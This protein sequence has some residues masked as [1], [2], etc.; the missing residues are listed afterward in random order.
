M[1]KS[2][3][4]FFNPKEVFEKLSQENSKHKVNFYNPPDL[5]NEK[6]FKAKD[7]INLDLNKNIGLIDP[8]S[9][10]I[11]KKDASEYNHK[12]Y[13]RR[14]SDIA[15]KPCSKQRILEKEQVARKIFR[16]E[17]PFQSLA[18]INGIPVL[19]ETNSAHM[20][21]F[22]NRNW[23]ILGLKIYDKEFGDLNKKI[24]YAKSNDIPIVRLINAIDPLFKERYELELKRTGHQFLCE[25]LLSDL[26]HELLYRNSNF[27]KPGAY[28]NPDTKTIVAL[29]TDYYGQ[30]KSWALGAVSDVGESLPYEKQFHS[31]HA[32]CAVVNGKAIAFVAPTGT[33]KS[34]QEVMLGTMNLWIPKLLDNAPEKV[35]NLISKELIT[36]ARKIKSQFHSDDWLYIDRNFNAI[37]SERH[38][39]P[40]TSFIDDRIPEEE[41]PEIMRNAKEELFAKALKENVKINLD[42][43]FIFHDSIGM[44]NSR[45]LANPADSVQNPSEG[46]S[47]TAPLTSVN[48]LLKFDDDEGINA[49][50]KE[51][52]KSG[53]TDE[54]C[55]LPYSI[56]TFEK[57]GEYGFLLSLKG[58]EKT[59]QTFRFVPTKFGPGSSSE[60]K[61]GLPTFEV[62]GTKYLAKPD[63]VLA[64]DSFQK[65]FYEN[66]GE[67]LNCSAINIGKSAWIGLGIKN[68]KERSWNDF[69]SNEQELAI[70]GTSILMAK[71]A[72]SISKKLADVLIKILQTN[73]ES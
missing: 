66:Y 15:E 19:L 46:L 33:G 35:K 14:R 12:T 22:W 20:F 25:D 42:N 48:I 7:I 6:S 51:I 47:F 65:E 30:L 1:Q 28:Y 54:D 72:G 44:P 58:K 16:D 9:G 29:N 18:L 56:K 8:E 43:E 73:A 49:V 27:E 32:A 4:L 31:L 36:E 53:F 5:F 24:D 71:Q 21:N 37:I 59:W 13:L 64:Y 39:Y 61:W 3:L 26:I 70:K 17:A 2:T 38:I 62:V 68:A 57:E 45:A 50:N 52:K 11:F 34:T 41:M 10:D 60:E 63:K 69:S 55:I 40:R 67:N 23:F